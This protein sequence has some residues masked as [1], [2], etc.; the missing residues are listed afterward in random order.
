M[1][2]S[3]RKGWVFLMGIKLSWQWREK[4]RCR[5]TRAES[6]TAFL[7]PYSHPKS[8]IPNSILEIPSTFSKNEWITL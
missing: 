7:P 2:R 6:R 8:F 4:Q 5:W 1:D 3:Q